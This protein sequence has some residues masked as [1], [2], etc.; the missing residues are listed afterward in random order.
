MHACRK[1]YNDAD[2]LFLLFFGESNEGD[3]LY[4]SL[5]EV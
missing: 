1:M 2:F 4:V 5:P 3:I